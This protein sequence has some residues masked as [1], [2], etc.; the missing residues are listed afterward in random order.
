MW[1]IA[2]SD[3]ISLSTKYQHLFH[4]ETQT[5]SWAMHQKQIGTTFN[6]Q[7]EFT[8]SL[9]SGKWVWVERL[10]VG[11]KCI[12]A[13]RLID[14]WL[15]YSSISARTGRINDEKEFWFEHGNSEILINI[16]IIRP[17]PK[18]IFSNDN[19]IMTPE[20]NNTKKINTP[21]DPLNLYILPS[22]VRK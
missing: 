18:T 15:I 4:L 11:I 13:L 20:N 16:I 5:F 10:A 12:G 21:L 6:I 1:I 14:F 22:N 17:Y 19:Q 3:I 9:I 7:K 8:P 2:A